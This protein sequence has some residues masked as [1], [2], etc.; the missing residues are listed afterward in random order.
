MDDVVILE[1]Q[2]PLIISE[3]QETLLKKSK[4]LSWQTD[5]HQSRR[6]FSSIEKF[7]AACWIRESNLTRQLIVLKYI[8]R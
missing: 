4:L 8:V 2:D 1:T 5:T 3:T 6:Y 7:E